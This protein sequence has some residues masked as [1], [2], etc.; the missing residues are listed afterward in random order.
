MPRTLTSVTSNFCWDETELRRIHSLDRRKGPTGIL[1]DPCDSKCAPL[2]GLAWQSKDCP[3]SALSITSQKSA[4][5]WLEEGEEDAGRWKA[6]VGRPWGSRITE[7]RGAQNPKL[8]TIGNQGTWQ[9]RS[10]RRDL[11]SST[12]YSLGQVGSAVIRYTLS[13]HLQLH[14]SCLIAPR[15][16]RHPTAHPCS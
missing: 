8:D 16:G 4:L 12:Q 9:P 2:K 5:C 3:C 15:P 6:C 10:A 11:R 14:E 1:P 7:R 13:S